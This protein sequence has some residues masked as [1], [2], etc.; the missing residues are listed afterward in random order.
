MDLG[1]KRG[2]TYLAD[3][4]AIYQCSVKMG[5]L[6]PSDLGCLTF[7]NKWPNWA[8]TLCFKGRQ[9]HKHISE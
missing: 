3:I 7:G 8:Y 6:N 2:R 5:S 4:V 9:V 1:G